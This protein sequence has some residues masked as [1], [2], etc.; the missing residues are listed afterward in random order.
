[1]GMAPASIPAASRLQRPP[2]AAVRL[3]TEESIVASPRYQQQH[4]TSVPL[5]SLAAALHSSP[6]PGIP[7]YT[8]TV[9]SR[10]AASQSACLPQA[11]ACLRQL[12]LPPTTTAGVR[13][14]SA[15]R[16]PPAV[17]S[18]CAKR[19]VKPS[20]L[21]GKRVV[22]FSSMIAV[23]IINGYQCRATASVPTGPRLSTT[24][25]HP[26]RCV[27]PDVTLR[28]NIAVL[29]CTAQSPCMLH[30]SAPICLLGN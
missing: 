13:N 3:T 12:P 2:P 29:H 16:W 30:Y 8:Y 18:R 1:M 22:L 10:V 11:I 7:I 28:D 17:G 15:R 20:P 23:L 4:G 24:Y 21:A 6:S 25:T 19:S 27:C 14:V 9:C 5:Q 26:A